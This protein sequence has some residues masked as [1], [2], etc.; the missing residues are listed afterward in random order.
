[1]GT[2]PSRSL[3]AWGALAGHRNILIPL[4]FHPDF[5]VEEV[6][7]LPDGDALLE[8]VDG[9][10]RRFERRA[11][12]RGGHQDGD[13]GIADQHAAETVHYG[14][15]LDLAARGQTESDL[16]HHFESHRLIALVVQ[17]QRGAAAGVVADRA[18]EE[19]GR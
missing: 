2:A 12:V 11:P 17:A 14:D 15:A 19:I 1:M 18:F 3:L 16:R 10:E 7:F 8:L 5:A 9:F 6:L 13:A 4:S